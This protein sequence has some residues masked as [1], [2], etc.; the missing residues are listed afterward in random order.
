[1]K[2]TKLIT[3]L[4][5]LATTAMLF[6][7]CDGYYTDFDNPI[8]IIVVENTNATTVPATEPTEAT[9]PQTECNESDGYKIGDCVYVVSNDEFIDASIRFGI[10]V[11][12]MDG[13]LA[14]THSVSNIGEDLE[15]M[16]AELTNASGTGDGCISLYP[17]ENCY[18]NSEEA[19]KAIGKTPLESLETPSGNI[20]D[21]K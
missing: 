16:L 5:A 17:V 8:P 12:E 7:G 6:A 18:R 9:I 13:Y 1:M 4:T 14:V 20:F 2:Y 21:G 3:G 19:W 11:T 10:V 15:A